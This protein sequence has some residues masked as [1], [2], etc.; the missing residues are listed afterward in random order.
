M[1]N[2]LILLFLGSVLS[3]CSLFNVSIETDVVPLSE[4]QMNL[5]NSI[6]SYAMA[7]NQF[8]VSNSDSLIALN[9]DIE[10][11]NEAILWK[12]GFTG[13]ISKSAFISDPDLSFIDT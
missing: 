4:R 10:G 12:I 13:A 5:R 2:L 9:D 8:V 3:G 7:M 11:Q 6:H 1:K